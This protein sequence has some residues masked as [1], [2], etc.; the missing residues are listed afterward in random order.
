MT[1][2]DDAPSD[3][4]P[5]DAA[6]SDAAPPLTPSETARVLDLV[7]TST[8]A[9]ELIRAPTHRPDDPLVVAPVV[10]PLPVPV[11]APMPLPVVAPMPVPVVAPMPVPVPAPEAAAAPAP[12]SVP[13]DSPPAVAD[14]DAASASQDAASASS[15]PSSASASASSAPTT[16]PDGAKDGAE[17][18]AIVPSYED[19]SNCLGH[20]T[21]SYL[22]P[23]LKL[24]GQR[25][26]QVADVGSPSRIDRADI[27]YSKVGAMWEEMSRAKRQA[28]AEAEAAG[29]EK[30]ERMRAAIREPSLFRA[31]Y[32]GFG[33]G[34]ILFGWAIYVVSA[35]LQFGPV[36][37]LNDLVRHFQSLGTDDVFEPRLNIWVEVALL[38]LLPN[39]V[40]LLQSRH[41]CIFAHVS[42]FVRTSVSTLLYRKA[43]NVSAA[44]RMQ[45]S[46]GQ[47]VNMMSNDTAQL[48]RFLQFLGFVSVA[49]L[50]IV[51]ALVMIFQQV[52]HATWV[53][54]GVMVVFIP[55]NVMVF[56]V[57]SKY[58]RTVIK[59]T[60]SRVKMI[61]EVLNGIRIIK[62]YAWEKPFR[63]TISEIR[64][65]EMQ[66]LTKLA[67]VQA[68]GFSMVLMSIPIIQPILVFLTY[69][70]I[71]GKPLD[72]ATAFTTVAL[73]NVMRFPFAFLPM[74]LVQYLQ[75][76]ISFLRLKKYMGLPEL[77]EYVVDGT[78]PDGNYGDGDAAP[79]VEIRHGSFNWL[80]PAE[81]EALAAAAAPKPPPPK[82]KS[83]FGKEQPAPPAPA[84][85]PEAEPPAASTGL[86][87]ISLTI[88][89]GSLVAVVGPVGS[90]KSS[91][92]SC[93]LG[94]MEALHS[95]RVY[96]PLSGAD[97][98]NRVGYCAQTPWIVNNTV[99]ENILFGRPFDRPRYDEVVAA[100]ALVDD[101]DVLPAG[102]QTEIGER[103]INLS[104]GQKARVSLARALYS[105]GAELL[106]LDDPL[107][108]VDS[109]VGEHLFEEAVCG[110]VCRGAARVLVTHRVHVLPRCDR[111]IVMKAGQIEHEGTYEELVAKGVDF[112]E[113]EDAGEGEV[114]EEALKDGDDEKM[115]SNTMESVQSVKSVDEK[116]AMKLKDKGENLITEE[117]KEGG[118]VATQAYLQYARAGGVCLFFLYVIVQFIG[119]G[120][121]VASSFWLSHWSTR[122]TEAYTPAGL[123]A[124][125]GVAFNDAFYIRIFTLFSMMGVLAM[126]IRS[127]MMAVHRL[128]ASRLIHQQLT[129]S[130]LR[131]P[132][133]FFDVTPMG[134][135][136]NRFA[137]DMDKIDLELTNSLGQG[138][139][140]ISQIFGAVGAIIIATKGSFLFPCIP[141]FFVYYKIQKWFRRT[142][143]NLQRVTSVTNS[144]I[145]TDFS[146]MLSGTSTIRAFRVQDRF[147]D[148]CISSFNTHNA[149]YTLVQLVNNWLGL[150]LDFLGGFISFFIGAVAV[151]FKDRNF[152]PAGWLGLA[153]SYSIEVTGYLKFG[154]RMI[155]TVE[156]QFTSVERV[157][158]YCDD[159]EPE[160]PED[161]PDAD[162]ATTAWPTGGAI[163]IDNISMRY[164]DGP[165]VLK[166]L[167]L[168]IDGGEKIGVV[169]RT[170]SGKSSL[171]VVLFRITELAEGRI[172]IDG[173]D[174]ANIGTRA[175]RSGLSIIPQ[176]P[177]LFSNTVRYNLDPFA[178]ETDA[179][180]WDAL[181]KV[182]LAD[183]VR[184][185]PLG[186]LEPVA[187]GGENFSQGQ[188]QLICIARALLRRPKILV[189]DEATA[190]IDNETDKFIQQMIRENFAEA[191]VLT[192]AHRLNT[193]MD[194]DRILVL[195]GGEM[196]EYDMPSVLL[197]KK[198]GVFKAMY[199]KSMA[200]R[201]SN[202]SLSALNLE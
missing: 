188:R 1:A 157:I 111:V 85:D 47:V 94:E 16:D 45:T 26:L 100:A 7:R 33:R 158:E 75:A 133:S 35:I 46:T 172:L 140:T 151:G 82:R 2:A 195:D 189:M 116:E 103:G 17:D 179:D 9:V 22:D 182:Q 70:R 90:G 68:V 135:V 117:V 77:G 66:A 146:Q 20:W 168:S 115:R 184:A 98:D 124:L 56:S 190:S 38:F 92:L 101:L 93:I 91:L 178:A 175:L 13:L 185:L 171:M 136:L 112:A 198:D 145:F 6:P 86:R 21:L 59:C 54:V 12:V 155:A 62:F 69:V 163:E 143:T 18:T 149:S 84:A 53:G 150:R 87:D 25:P 44:G 61:N 99:R 32:V 78:H 166:N 34:P 114:T 180:I 80:D 60:D 152:I 120:F 128:R 49:P 109:H 200:S 169:G 131:A 14:G 88:Q 202:T 110:D 154:V 126:T 89:P 43:L 107:S 176:D 137:A 167:S 191:T 132:V 95:S 76:K 162:P 170:G 192:I 10:A 147:F 41:N 186:L 57:I 67:Y 106:L 130:V 174:I 156:E 108:A 55:V 201:G 144:P 197:K 118:E 105:A 64:E 161:R 50:Q 28:L 199:N 121:E 71:Q 42:V 160:A 187:E 194:S 138:V 81:A 29:G 164:R 31:L 40:S 104:G 142:S 72:A 153:L 79:I 30:G 23:L 148:K 37:I 96:V 127:L 193:I 122:S 141:V 63:G 119:R 51:L 36:F 183:A 19:G 3:V 24:G 73:F 134:R 129:T 97:T 15:S 125:D 102:D 139:S 52:G 58:R 165:L 27:A 48:Q 159:I 4:P 65:A 74:G 181:T 83:F 113:E 39:A 177:V 196:A 11:V 5:S 123:A 8:N 173:V